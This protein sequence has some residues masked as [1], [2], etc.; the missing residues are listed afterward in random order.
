MSQA[1]IFIIVF[2]AIGF[3]GYAGLIVYLVKHG[4]LKPKE[5]PHIVKTV[6]LDKHGGNSTVTTSTGSA[7]GRGLVGAA[8]AG[9]VGA[10]VG[11]GTAKQKVT[12]S[13]DEYV[14]RVFWDNDTVTIEKCR[15]NSDMYNK[16]IEKLEV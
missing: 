10:V 15:Y 1:A 6:L 13:A 8:I 2:C 3:G 4:K 16:C 9:P 14:F 5:E 7:V 11:A 12:Q